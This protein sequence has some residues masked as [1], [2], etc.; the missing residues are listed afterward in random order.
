MSR[1]P[2]ASDWM[3]NLPWVLLGVR[4]STRDDSAI[5]P[6]HMVYGG[7][8]RLPGEFFN[9]EE[10]VP[11][12]TS[13]FVTQLR[14]S[15]R[16][17]LPFPADFHGGQSR[18]SPLPISLSSCPA[19]FVRV[20]AVKRPL[21]PPYVGPYQVLERHEKTFLVMRSGKPWT[22]SVDRLKPFLPPVLSAPPSL[23]S[24]SAALPPAASTQCAAPPPAAS[25]QCAVPPPPA[26]TSSSVPTPPPQASGAVRTRYGREVRNPDRYSA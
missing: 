21:T 24:S 4:S 20:D 16:D 23:S 19:V 18:S 8:L 9:S 5:S 10:R 14:N 11:V 2:N 12:Q 17:L 7:P 22:V 15:V 26:A 6:A 3:Q 13:E 25:T 1:S